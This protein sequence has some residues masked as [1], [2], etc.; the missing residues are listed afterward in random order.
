M[1][2][3]VIALLIAAIPKNLAIELAIILIEQ[4]VKAT[5]TEFDDNLFLPVLERMREFLKN[6]D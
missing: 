1:N 4:I 3:Q 5:P 2:P 6:Q